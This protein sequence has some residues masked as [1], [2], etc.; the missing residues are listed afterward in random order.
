MNDFMND[1]KIT[2]QK[3]FYAPSS[4]HV[5]TLHYND[6]KMYDKS[7]V[8]DGKWRTS[9]WFDS[10]M[11][12]RTPESFLNLKDHRYGNIYPGTTGEPGAATRQPTKMPE[13]KIPEIKMAPTYN[14]PKYEA[15]KMPE[16]KALTTSGTPVGGSASGVKI[17]R[18]KASQSP[19]K[20]GTTSLSRGSRNPSLK[21]SNLNLA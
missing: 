3:V 4:Q 14:A 17:K 11:P 20:R 13:M 21:I 7:W 2:S 12:D 16:P 1:L 6:G 15:P 5:G 8:V 9:S 10:F 18:S 19:S